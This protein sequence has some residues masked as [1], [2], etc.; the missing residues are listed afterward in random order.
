MFKFRSETLLVLVS[1]FSN[2][3]T[4]S[5]I[6]S[7]LKYTQDADILVM[8]NNPSISDSEQRT[9]SFSSCSNSLGQPV[10]NGITQC[11]IERRHLKRFENLHIIQTP[12]KMSH[13]KCLNLAMHFANSNKYKYLVHVEPDCVIKGSR[14]YLNLMDSMQ[15]DFWMA[16]S[17]IYFTGHIHLTPSVWKIGETNFLD[18]EVCSNEGFKQ[19]PEFTKIYKTEIN[20]HMQNVVDFTK[21]YFDTGVRAWYYCAKHGKAKLIKNPDLIHLWANSSNNFNLFL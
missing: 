16:G 17:C 5:C 3:W 21:K 15:Q 20:F 19:D 4:Q 1:Y 18:F 12:H 10:K 14:W 7:L 11:E 13:G 2:G 6:R 9:K 8:D